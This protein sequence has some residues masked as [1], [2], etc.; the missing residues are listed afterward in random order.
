MAAA[1]PN[2]VAVVTPERLDSSGW[3]RGVIRSNQAADLFYTLHNAALHRNEID[4]SASH[5][6]PQIDPSALIH[7]SA[8]IE[9]GV[10]IGKDVEVRAGAVINAGT[11]IGSNTIIEERVTI[12]SEGLFAKNLFGKRTHVR[13]FG[14]VTIG[15]DCFVHA[16]TNI[17]RSVNDGEST[18]IGDQVHIGVL[19]I[20]GHDCIVGTNTVISSGAIIA[21]R[22]R[23]GAGC[24]IG[25][26][27]KISN[28]ITVEDGAD[29][30]IGATVIADVGKDAEVSGNFAIPHSRNI[31]HWLRNKSDKI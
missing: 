20:I 18:L 1:N 5:A 30:K 22:V 10:E 19:S 17:A 2:V 4:E 11:K 3:S 24:W 6:E 15:T 21:G 26:G 12:G 25:S 31:K 14:D 7:P 27:A 29:I 8:I 13:H 28:A 9:S 23:I 16:G